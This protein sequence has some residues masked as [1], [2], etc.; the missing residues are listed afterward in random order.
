MQLLA[1]AENQ[2]EPLSQFERRIRTIEKEKLI[3]NQRK[4]E[5]LLSEIKEPK[6]ELALKAIEQVN[7]I[8]QKRLAQENQRRVE[9]L[10]RQTRLEKMQGEA[11]QDVQIS[12]L[13][14]EREQT[15][16]RQKVRDML[17]ESPEK[18]SQLQLQLQQKELNPFYQYLL[19][20]PQHS[21]KKKQL[22]KEEL[23]LLLNH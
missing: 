22:S 16:R 19:D 18:P 21:Q 9:E 7:Q 2:I 13:I 20:N 11:A 23:R 17:Q 10:R 3:K 5:R 1:N 6:S 12:R 8:R 14:L 4:R 15:E